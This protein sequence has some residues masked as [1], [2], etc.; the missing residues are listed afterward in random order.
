MKV[1]HQ[2]GFRHKWNISSFETNSV[3]DGLIYS[4]VNVK[5]SD[6]E[7]LDLSLRETSFLDPQIYLPSENKGMLET[8][9]Y[10][11]VNIVDNFNTVDFSEHYGKLASECVSFQLK[12]NF[13]YII[14]PARYYEEIPSSYFEQQFE[15]FIN[16]FCEYIR[17][18]NI[19]K[20]IL[21]T[22]IVKSIMLTDKQKREDLLNWITGI[23]NIDGIY[24]I[25]ENSFTSK[26]IKDT[27][28]LYSALIFI[29][30]LKI[31]QLEV[32]IGYSNVEGLLYSVANPDSISIGSYENLRSFNYKR[33]LDLENSVQRSPNARIYSGKL[34]QWIDYS[35]LAGLK[36]LYP[37]Y[38]ELFEE[39][40]YK[41]L[42]FVPEYKW[43]FAKP[44]P[45][46]HY[47]YVFFNQVRSL[48]EDLSER[49]NYLKNAFAAAI[50]L[51]TNISDSG[52]LLD[53]NSDGSHLYI[54]TTVLNMYEKFLTSG[55]E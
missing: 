3:G 51:F 24:V 25:F 37:N 35:Y 16:P 48:P 40:E 39:S 12:N 17:L 11:P 54:W 10:F 47:F 15:Y 19:D 29:N 4:P 22:V 8:Y 55:H 50:K 27:N 6:I 30:A 45:Y 18:N 9:S 52:V 28:Y 21:L 5:S 46:L 53:P 2:T 1:F 33:F 41:P 14:I 34:F 7:K 32:H 13:E 36:T 49:I 31:N 43:H 26:Q 42:M 38:E 44:Q 23:Q 20:K